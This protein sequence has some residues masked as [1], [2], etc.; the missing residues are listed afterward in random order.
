MNGSGIAPQEWN[1]S[2]P[3]GFFFRKC[4]LISL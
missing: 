4:S 2:F 3:S 1:W